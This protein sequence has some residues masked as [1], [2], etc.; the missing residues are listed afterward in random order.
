M[1]NI[2][3]I[4][5]GPQSFVYTVQ[6]VDNATGNLSNDP[7]VYDRAQSKSEIITEIAGLI[8]DASSDQR[9]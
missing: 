4:N 9:L 1:G 7:T 3:T 8:N 5:I 6:G 2:I